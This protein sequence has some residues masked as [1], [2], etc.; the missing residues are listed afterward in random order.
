MEGVEE[1]QTLLH[2][3]S[4]SN[5][6]L[7]NHLPGQSERSSK[8][9]FN[10]VDLIPSIKHTL[11][12]F[13]GMK[14]EVAN[15][16]SQLEVALKDLKFKEAEVETLRQN[17][18][19][20]ESQFTLKRNEG[21]PSGEVGPFLQEKMLLESELKQVKEELSKI[22]SLKNDS[23]SQVERHQVEI[24]LLQKGEESLPQF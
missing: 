11:S 14:A 19:N 12:L 7:A 20:L 4:L 9:S 5:D 16:K 24:K 8:T 13:E 1:L 2:S 17:L 18:N 23:S 21:S 10:L 22:T 6:D 15:A 3:L